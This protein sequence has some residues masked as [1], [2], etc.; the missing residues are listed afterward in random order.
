MESATVL[1]RVA[2]LYCISIISTFP[3]VSQTKIMGRTLLHARERNSLGDI[4]EAFLDIIER[5]AEIHRRIKS[6]ISC[7]GFLAQYNDFISPSST[8]QLLRIEAI[9]AAMKGF[10]NIVLPIGSEWEA[11]V[12]GSLSFLL[13]VWSSHSFLLQLLTAFTKQVNTS[14][15]SREKLLKLIE[16][17]S[18][19]V[20]LPRATIHGVAGQNETVIRAILLEIYGLVVYSLA[21]TIQFLRRRPHGL[22][23]NSFRYYFIRR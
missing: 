19:T 14:V 9:A 13:T 20:A 4:E 10:L 21:H 11:L 8:S 23:K 18:T 16:G 17:R 3:A 12:W 22:G 15:S 6:V 5:D 7:S 1:F 2:V